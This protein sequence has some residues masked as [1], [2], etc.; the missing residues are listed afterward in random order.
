MRS[1]GFNNS[2]QITHCMAGAKRP[3][4][5]PKALCNC[6][7]VRQPGIGEGERET[8]FRS[9]LAHQ[10][11]TRKARCGQRRCKRSLSRPTQAEGEALSA[12]NQMVTPGGNEQRTTGA[13]GGGSGSL[14]FG[15]RKSTHTMPCTTFV[16]KAV[17]QA[18]GEETAVLAVSPES[19]GIDTQAPP[20][21]KVQ[22]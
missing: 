2:T 19:C 16:W 12:R 5:S 3:T 15:S 11:R 14:Q 4:H 6:K 21:A 7:G 8:K 18:R 10:Q 9:R 22:P 17:A 13:G 1:Q 20:P